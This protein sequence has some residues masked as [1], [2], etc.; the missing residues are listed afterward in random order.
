MMQTELDILTKTSHVCPSGLGVGS[1]MM[2]HAVDSK[3][4]PTKHFQ[5]TQ[6]NLIN[7]EAHKTIQRDYVKQKLLDTKFEN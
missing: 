2:M 3:Q 6:Q 1:Q 7:Q 5:N 4:S